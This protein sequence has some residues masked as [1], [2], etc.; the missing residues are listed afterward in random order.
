MNYSGISDI[1]Y[2]TA[3]PRTRAVTFKQ[4][5]IKMTKKIITAVAAFVMVF[6]AFGAYGSVSDNSSVITASAAEI[7]DSGT[8]WQ[9]QD[10][11]LDDEGTLTITS[12]GSGQYGWIEEVR[13]RAKKVVFCE[14]ITEILPD[15]FKGDENLTEIVFPES[16]I[17]IDGES[18]KNC[19]GLKSVTIPENVQMISGWA[20]DNCNNLSD[21]RILSMDVHIG[22][23]AFGWTDMKDETDH[24]V[25][26]P[27]FTITCYSGS[28]AEAYAIEHGWGYSIMRKGTSDKGDV[29]GDGAI[30]VTDI[31]KIAAHVKGIK[32]LTEEEQKRADAN[33]DGSI[34]VTDISKIAAHVKGIKALS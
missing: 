3:P 12:V 10:W 13:G 8:S 25:P 30:T 32:S 1:I 15:A 2:D 21:V 7:V 4:E 6:G 17:D 5:E 19:K 23:N 27:G 18:F 26:V 9:G 28:T 33:G 11:T 24:F 14:G 20:F 16:L 22:D 31:S 34:T 29:N